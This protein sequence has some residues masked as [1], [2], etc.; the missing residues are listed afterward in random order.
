MKANEL[1]EKEVGK[2]RQQSRNRRNRPKT[3]AT[4]KCF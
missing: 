2:G 3:K 4:V 1:Y